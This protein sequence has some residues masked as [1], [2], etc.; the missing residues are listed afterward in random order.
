LRPVVD[1]TAQSRIRELI[2]DAYAEYEAAA[3]VAS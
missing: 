1:T 3:A 2:L